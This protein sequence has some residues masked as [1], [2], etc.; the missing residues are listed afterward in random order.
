MIQNTDPYKYLIFQRQDLY[1]HVI[2]LLESS[3]P[4]HP[5]Q[6]DRTLHL[7]S[8]LFALY[9]REVHNEKLS[10]SL[11]IIACA[12]HEHL[13][14][15]LKKYGLNNIDN[16]TFSKI[17]RFMGFE[18]PI[19]TKILN[20][21]FKHKLK[22]LNLEKITHP[23]IGRLKHS[24][25]RKLKKL[26]RH[27]KK[28]RDEILHSH[29]K[30]S[31]KK[32]ENKLIQE[33]QDSSNI[34]NRRVNI[35]YAK[36]LAET[37][38]A[39]PYLEG[40]NF[41]QTLASFIEDVKQ[42]DLESSRKQALTEELSF[43]QQLADDTSHIRKLHTDPTA[44]Q[45]AQTLLSQCSQKI[46]KRLRSLNVGN[47][48]TIPVGTENH[49][50]LC[51]AKKEKNGLFSFIIKNTGIGSPTPKDIR[52]SHLTQDVVYTDVSLDNLSDSFIRY[53]LA[54]TVKTTKIRVVTAY[55]DA[56]LKKFLGSNKKLGD[57]LYPKQTK[58]TCTVSVLFSWLEDRLGK[59][60]FLHFK[61]KVV[62]TSAKSL[63]DHFSR[64]RRLT[65]A[66]A[67]LGTRDRARIA[68]LS[69]Q[70][71]IEARQAAARARAAAAA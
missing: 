33:L 17:K 32:I 20:A 48:V 10:P 26:V 16:R 64:T 43:A 40:L 41:S 69:Q 68:L 19:N 39:I 71:I 12:Y 4:T 5:S 15:S 11:R 57:H 63:A 24:R 56:K 14:L 7:V 70:I 58:G 54:F 66:E 8:K 53:L 18:T 52:R 22:L 62:E 31:T 55:I 9:E 28:R 42:S 60:E 27:N 2:H 35:F 6:I 61:S 47:S 67:T 38:T 59:R 23:L 30:K 13:V 37:E 44:L 49:G 46:I 3:H 34:I 65:V 45:S 50:F 36:A 51:I 1:N 25:I 29:N 21:Y